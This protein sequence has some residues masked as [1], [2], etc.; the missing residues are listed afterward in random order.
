MKSYIELELENFADCSKT[1]FRKE[2]L[3][4]FS[5][6]LVASL[7]RTPAVSISKVI[8]VQMYI[9]VLSRGTWGVAF[10]LFFVL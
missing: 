9:F 7:R 1:V 3:P 6:F 5:V 10:V 4:I 8:S 2:N